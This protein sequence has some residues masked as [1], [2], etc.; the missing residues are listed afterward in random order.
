MKINPVKNYTAPALPNYAQA[1]T[2]KDLLHKMPMRWQKKTAVLACMAFVGVMS[3]SGC[4][5]DE[6]LHGGG[7]PQVPHYVVCPTEVDAGRNGYAMTALEQAIGLA[8][9]ELRTH[10]GGSGW[11]PFYVVHLTEADA[12]RIV[13]VMLEGAGLQ[14]G[15]R[16]PAYNVPLQGWRD[17]IVEILSYDAQHNVGVAHITWDMNNQP[18]FS[19]GGA[20]LANNVA[21]GFDVQT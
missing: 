3:L 15:A 10:T 2:Q 21:A 9:L 1:R 12:Q 19:H 6:W 8:E 17:D 16:L 7:A 14:F 4:D 5:Y 20:W 18:F 11:G 13:R